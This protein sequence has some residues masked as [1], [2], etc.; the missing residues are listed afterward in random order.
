M[1]SAA[2]REFDAWTGL[3]PKITSTTFGIGRSMTKADRNVFLSGIDRQAARAFH[4]YLHDA[5]NEEMLYAEIDRALRGPFRSLP[6]T[7]VFGERNDP[8]GFQPLWKQRFPDVRQIVVANGNHFPMC[9]DPDLVAK[10]IRD[11]HHRI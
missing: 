3:L 7:T 11:L 10:A 2:V 5:R 4:A 9:D 8:L 6:V 1:G